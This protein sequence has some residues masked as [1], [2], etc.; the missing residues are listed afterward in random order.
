M[1]E[2][3]GSGKFERSVKALGASEAPGRAACDWIAGARSLFGSP[4]SNSTRIEDEVSIAIIKR[5][6]LDDIDHALVDPAASDD[7]IS[8]ELI[9]NAQYKL[10]SA[11]WF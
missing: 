8:A 4:W 6:V 5:S 3:F 11:L 10:S 1:A 2:P 9:L 7:K